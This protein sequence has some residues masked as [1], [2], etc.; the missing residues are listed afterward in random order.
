MSITFD[1]IS[2]AIGGVSDD[3]HP[4]R[5]RG[6]STSI[7]YSDGVGVPVPRW[8]R[9]C[10]HN[11]LMFN[12]L[13]DDSPKLY[14]WKRGGSNT[15]P[16]PRRARAP[17]GNTAGTSLHQGPPFLRSR[18]CKIGDRMQLQRV[19]S[20]PAFPFD[21]YQLKTVENT[22]EL[23]R[24]AFSYPIQCVLAKLP[25]LHFNRDLFLSASTTPRLPKR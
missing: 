12:S 9:L 2:C 20:D 15:R 6:H 21:N 22:L 7:A 10:P 3:H 17:P 25:D 4:G 16:R 24:C 8:L 11:P 14:S 23:G 1:N 19:N 5:S 13:E 18:T